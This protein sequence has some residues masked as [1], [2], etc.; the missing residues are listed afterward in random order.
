M[1]LTNENSVSIFERMLR[2]R[3]FEE[4]II[5]LSTDKVY[6]GHCHVY[7]GQ[8][9]TGATIME[10]LKEG[11]LGLST[12]R[13]HGHMIGRGA[14]SSRAMAEIM[15]R[16]DGF[17]KGRAGS[18]SMCDR[19]SGFISA[20]GVVGGSLGL[21]IG[22]AHAL[23]IAG[24]RAISVAF[25]GDGALEEGIAYEALNIAKLNSLP[26]LFV[27]ENNSGGANAGRAGGEWSSTALSAKRLVDIPSSLSIKSEK[28]DGSDIEAV[29]EATSN[30]IQTIRDG[31]GPV[32]IEFFTER[33]PGS[34]LFR[35]R[36]LTG[37]MDISDIWN[38][39]QNKGEHADWVE[40]H[41][42]V[43]KT[44]RLLMEKN[45][46]TKEDIIAIDSKYQKEMSNSKVFACN[47]KYADETT[48][49]SGTF[50]Q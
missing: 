31:N 12:H 21:G 48:V 35:A 40:N 49:L 43:I 3:R 2:I 14:D 45:I 16:V 15:G 1:G 32:F 22:A 4:T 20:T 38:K 44:A 19:S 36:Q 13:N 27:C 23:K 37:Q 6:E 50:A 28:V 26:I 8:E 42:P 30:S 10:A 17:C 11:D 47:S 33:W 46:L 29:W 18:S 34:R 41:D 24:N 7:I 25:F 9:A 39:N 5:Q